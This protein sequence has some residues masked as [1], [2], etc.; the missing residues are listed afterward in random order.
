MTVQLEDSLQQN[1]EEPEAPRDKD[2]MTKE[3]A[4]EESWYDQDTEISRS[5]L[6]DEIPYWARGIIQDE[7]KYNETSR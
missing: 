6:R 4:S 2:T 1:E 7:E 3:R 5:T